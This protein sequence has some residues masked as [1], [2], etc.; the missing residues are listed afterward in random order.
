MPFNYNLYLMWM[1][2]E[3]SH[4]LFLWKLDLIK[5]VLVIIIVKKQSSAK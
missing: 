1:L 2:A 3:Q 4:L 5:S